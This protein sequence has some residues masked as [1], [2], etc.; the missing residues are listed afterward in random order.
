MGRM[1]LRYVASLLLAALLVSPVAGA[2]AVGTTPAAGTEAVSGS[3]AAVQ[4]QQPQAAASE[5]ETSIAGLCCA[6]QSLDGS[7]VAFEGEAVGDIIKAGGPMRW[8]AITADEATISVYCTADQASQ[9]GRLGRYG[10]IGDRLRVVGIYNIACTEHQGLP[11]VHATDIARIEDG[12]A[13]PIPVDLGHL[14]IGGALLAL[15][16]LLLGLRRYLTERVR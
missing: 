12:Y 13:F 14:Q 7:M 11:D 3:Q 9:A 10:Q 5:H 16:V 4:T 6:D 15:S 2:E 8:L 1:R